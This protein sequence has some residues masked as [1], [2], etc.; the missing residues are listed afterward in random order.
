MTTDTQT[1]VVTEPRK[2]QRIS[3]YRSP[4]SREDLIALN[5]RSDFKGFLQTGGFLGLLIVSGAAALWSIGRLPWPFVVLIFIFHGIC[6]NFLINGFH[7]LIHDSVFRT[8]LLNRLFLWVH[9]FWGWYS[10][11]HFWASHTEHHKYTL[12]PPDDLEVVLP[13]Q[14]SLSGYLKRVVID[15]WGF[16]GT[17]KLFWRWAIGR[18]EGEWETRLFPESDPAHRRGLRNWARFVLL[19]HALIVAGSIVL[20]FAFS[21]VWWFLPLVT[22]FS[23]FHGYWLFFLCNTSQHIGLVD[24]VPDFRLC[25]RTIILSPF[26]RFLYWHMNYHTEHHMY[27]A[28]PCYNLGRLHKLIRDD[29]PHCP[30]G[31]IETWTQIV[32]ILK[33]QKE[34]PSYQFE[35]ELPTPTTPQDDQAADN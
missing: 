22:T 4:V 24:N 5:R 14:L 29:M 33:K 16:W 8:R 12:H 25:C 30:R 2:P 20:G 19:G 21:Y 32:R 27:A 23:R 11:V 28:V 13:M 17:I 7:E 1:P 3:W 10:H 34:D 9:S 6:A 26:V 15:P 18:V 35:A 31:L